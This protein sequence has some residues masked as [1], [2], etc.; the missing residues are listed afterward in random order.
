MLVGSRGSRLSLVQT[1]HV[2]SLL[3]QMDGSLEF[4]VVTVKTKGDMDARPLYRMDGKGVFEKEVD[5][6]V[7]SGSVHFAVHSMKDVPSDL[8]DDLVIASV[9]RRESPYDIFIGRSHG[10]MSIPSDSVI[11]TSSL[12]RLVQL[13]RVRSDLMF[14]PI[15]GNVDTR[16]AKMR[17]GEYD[18]LVL[19]EAGLS[20]LALDLDDLKVERLSKDTMMPAPGQGALAVVARKDDRDLI[21]LLKRIED[22][23]SR[24]EVDAERSL[25][26]G[27]SAGCRLPLGA[28]A[29]AHP[30]GLLTLEAC[31]FSIDGRDVIMG[32]A[33]SGMD[34]AE[35]LGARVAR[36]LLEQ[37][38]S[39][40]S[41][42]WRSVEI[43]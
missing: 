13:K 38:A 19:A 26:A 8:H 6:A 43:D 24:A 21:A 29:R 28:L 30:S 39:R 23:A 25:L 32:R 33:S 22:R 3:R 10:L 1:E 34:D 40:I 17:N 37:G 7:L 31:I 12:R 41:E 20:R 2:I 36:A 14:K 4:E 9:P 5:Q 27:V 42:E 15:R 35:R 16:I 18:A 11:G